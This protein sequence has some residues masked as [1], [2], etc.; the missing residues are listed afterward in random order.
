MNAKQIANLLEKY[1]TYLQQKPTEWLHLWET[2][3][4]FQQKWNLE[5][6]D[7]LTMY[8]ESLQNTHT[9]R[10][11]KRRA[12][13][14]KRMM[15]AFM[16]MAPDVVMQMFQDL[17]NEN[18]TLDGRLGRFIFY[19]DE[20][21]A[22]FKSNKPL[23]IDNNHYHQNDYEMISLYLSFVYPDKYAPYHHEKFVKMM[24]EIGAVNPPLVPDMER[25]AKVCRTLYKM[26]QR[27]EELMRLHQNRLIPKESFEG[28][29]LLLVYEFYMTI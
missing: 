13:E 15:M 6:S 4:I 26:M 5:T 1:K 7:F 18:K 16:E 3:A 29:S 24:G 9:K 12:Y 23:S 28:D 21:L 19:C 17:L 22:E 8:N 11:W 10:L 14:P 20:L 2:Q 25:F 27:D